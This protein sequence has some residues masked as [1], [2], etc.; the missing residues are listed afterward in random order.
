MN[1]WRNLAFLFLVAALLVARQQDVHAIGVY[2]DVMSERE[3]EP[4]EE[5]DGFDAFCD[6]R[7]DPGDEV[8]FENYYFDVWAACVDYCEH[9]D[10]PSGPGSGPECPDFLSSDIIDADPQCYVSCNCLCY[11]R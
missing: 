6:E 8:G 7:C 3:C 2:L 9:S 5:V 4:S 11:G 10:Y 1:T